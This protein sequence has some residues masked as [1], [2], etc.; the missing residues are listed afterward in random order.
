MNL[1]AR[2]QWFLELVQNY[3]VFVREQDEYDDDNDEPR[4]PATIA[5]HQRYAT[6]LYLILFIGK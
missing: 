3:N 4:D 2:I 5:K 1:K 6:R